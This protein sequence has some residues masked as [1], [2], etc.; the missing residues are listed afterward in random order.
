MGNLVGCVGPFGYYVRQRPKAPA[1][2]PTEAQLAVRQRM[3]LVMAFLKPLRKIIYRGFGNGAGGRTGAFNRATAHALTHAVGG[4]YPGQF[5]VPEGIRVSH[6]TLPGLVDPEC[7][8]SA[9]VVRLAWAMAR[10]MLMAYGDDVVS[11]LAYQV[12]ADTVLLGE[13]EREDG[14]LTVR[15]DGELPGN[16]VLAYAFVCSRNGKSYS[17]SQFLG[18]FTVGGQP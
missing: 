4:E 14:T 5:I 3:K 13:G 12:E 16:R 2:P 9:G 10:P 17:N 18:E 1:K 11:L 6:G 8:F 7:T 15:I